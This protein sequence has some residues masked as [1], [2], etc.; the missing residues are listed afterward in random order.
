MQSTR[1]PRRSQ[2]HSALTISRS[3]LTARRIDVTRARREQ[4]LTA[5]AAGAALVLGAVGGVLVGRQN[6][7]AALARLSQRG[8]L[9]VAAA[10]RFGSERLATSL[11]PALDALDAMA[12]HGERA[13]RTRALVLDALRTNG[14]VPISPSVGDKFNDTHMETA[15]SPKGV[16]A[17]LI[18]PGYMLHGE[19]VLRAAQVGTGVQADA[20]GGA[21]SV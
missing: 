17:S 13:R 19:R 2:L 8:A 15:D 21:T 3:L 11:L 12:E 18:R 6:Q 5:A 20:D 7:A 16:V 4:R 1:A 9:D 14:V 10:E